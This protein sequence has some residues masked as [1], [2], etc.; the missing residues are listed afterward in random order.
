MVLEKHEKS[1]LKF[2]DCFMLFSPASFYHAKY[3]N[4]LL[5]QAAWL[6]QHTLVSAEVGQGFEPV[7]LEWPILG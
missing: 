4:V 6:K 1:N 3:F 2:N 7:G 5:A